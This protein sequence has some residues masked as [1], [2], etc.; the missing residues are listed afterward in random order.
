[1]TPR[2]QLMP[3]AV[4]VAAFTTEQRRALMEQLQAMG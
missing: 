4:D 2:L 1:M 3:S